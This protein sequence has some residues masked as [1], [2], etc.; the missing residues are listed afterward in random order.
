MYVY[1][2]KLIYYTIESSQ[3]QKHGTGTLAA[4]KGRGAEAESAAERLG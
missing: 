2:L 3:A 1:Y 4:A